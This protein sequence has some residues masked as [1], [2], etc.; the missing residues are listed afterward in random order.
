MGCIADNKY[1]AQM[2]TSTPSRHELWQ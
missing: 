1:P 2:N